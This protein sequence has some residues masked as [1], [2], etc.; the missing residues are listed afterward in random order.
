[1]VNLKFFSIF[2]VVFIAALSRLIPHPPNFTPIIA[3]GLF[4]GAYLKNDR[5]LAFLLPLCSMIVSDL[6]L[7]FYLISIIVYL[8]LM[9]IVFVG[10][11]INKNKPSYII[12]GSI[13]SSIIF[14]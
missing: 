8:C 1:M 2:L 5:K 3:I 12:S 9:L 14:L 13:I 11:Q 6:F 4:S 10:F 7:G